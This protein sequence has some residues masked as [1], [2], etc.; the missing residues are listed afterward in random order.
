MLIY[1]PHI[2]SRV[3]YI[4]QYVFEERLGLAYSITNDKNEYLNHRDTVKITYSKT[5][6][7]NGLFF[8]ADDLL[9]ENDIKEIEIH[10]GLFNNIKILF[11][12][13]KINVL[14]FDVFAAM[15][16]L[17]SR[18]EEYLGKP[19]I[20]HG[21]Y[22]YKNSI[23]YKL[24]VLDTPI[25]E[26][27]I[28]LLKDVLLK[29]FPSL[30]FK[31]HKPAAALSFDVDVAYA[32]KGRSFV[33]TA[34]GIVKKILSFYF[35]EA[36]NQLL[37]L[38]DKRKDM[39]DTYDYVFSLIKKRKPL[40]FFNMGSYAEFDKNPSYKNKAFQNLIKY[41]AEKAAIGLHPS[42]ASNSNQKLITAE[43][44]KLEYILGKKIIASRQHYLK[45]KMPSTFN[46]LINN[47]I[48]Q[49][50][51]LGYYYT[52]GF[53]AG[54]CNSFLFF[55]LKQNEATSLR[56]F[57]YAYMDGT[58]ND[59]LKMSID[60]AKSVVSKL[61]DI[62]YKYNGIFIPL[63]HN[64]TLYNRNEWEGWR[65]VFEHTVKEIDN[66]NFENLFN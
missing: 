66:R 11:A 52:Y 55:N 38:L 21:N 60:E 47:N 37:T 16:Y 9:F 43:K 61:V 15:F 24:N 48:A 50:Y 12:H 59:I 18:Y 19:T 45:L 8:Y 57:P 31:Q 34:G 49:D 32:Y 5:G 33:R 14:S 26:Q 13:N 17:L 40:Y 25:A 63:W 46:N 58:L 65:E 28:E 20:Q 27:W 1:T 54:T 36:N 2:T 30:Q 53:R 23:L 35:S 56:L 7:N 6:L 62:T 41:V 39:Y 29:N 42:Y 10:V 22:D 3:Q 64:S 51:T 44:E 4:F